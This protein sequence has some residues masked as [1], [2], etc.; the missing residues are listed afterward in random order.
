MIQNPLSGSWNLYLPFKLIYDSGTDLNY[1]LGLFGV[2]GGL[3]VTV[4]IDPVP[5]S[6]TKEATE[7]PF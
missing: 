4:E 2:I 7:V 5:K 6:E 1:A 3:L